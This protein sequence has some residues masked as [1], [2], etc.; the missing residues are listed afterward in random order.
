[1]EAWGPDVEVKVYGPEVSRVSESDWLT[2]TRRR[3]I[4]IE[5]GCGLGKST[6]MTQL[7]HGSARSLYVIA[8]V[9]QG[10]AWM[11]AQH[12][13]S[14]ILGTIPENVVMY[15]TD[16]W[17]GARH[18]ACTYESLWKLCQ[19]NAPFVDFSTVFLDEA[20]SIMES[21][22]S[23]TNSNHML[24]NYQALELFM[25]RASRVVVSDAHLMSSIGVAEFIRNTFDGDEVSLRVF[26]HQAITPRVTLFDHQ[27]YRDSFSYNSMKAVTGKDGAPAFVC[28]SSLGGVRQFELVSDGKQTEMFT[29]KSDSNRMREVWNDPDSQLADHQGIIATS[30][31]AIGCD[32]TI[33]VSRVWSDIT[34]NNGPDGRTMVQLCSRARNC[35]SRE[36]YALADF[37]NLDAPQHFEDVV[38]RYRARRDARSAVCKTAV[39][40]GAAAQIAADSAWLGTATDSRRSAPESELRSQ[41]E[42]GCVGERMVEIVWAPKLLVRLAARA[43]QSKTE[44]IS[45]SF[46]RHGL[47]SGWTF[48]MPTDELDDKDGAK[49]TSVEN[50]IT[51]D[52]RDDRD[53]AQ[54]KSVEAMYNDIDFEQ[55]MELLNGVRE[56]MKKRKSTEEDK[57]AMFE[58]LKA[59]VLFDRKPPFAVAMHAAT[60]RHLILNHLCFDIDENTLARKDFELMLSS[61]GDVGSRSRFDADRVSRMTKIATLAGFADAREPGQT[62]TGAKIEENRDAIMAE[63]DAILALGGARKSRAAGKR[64]VAAATAAAITRVFSA[65]NGYEVKRSKRTRLNGVRAFTYELVDVYNVNEFAKS[66]RPVWL[67]STNPATVDPATLE[68]PVTKSQADAA[69][70]VKARRDAGIMLQPDIAEMISMPPPVSREPVPHDDPTSMVT[71][72]QAAADYL[73]TDV[74]D[75]MY[76]ESSGWFADDA[77]ERRRKRRRT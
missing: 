33:P 73:G 7:M 13:A 20:C 45:I 77:A 72:A 4:G 70:R 62:T 5:A 41:W 40:S 38:D 59:M 26:K 76:S 36:I 25:S 49:R 29:G 11:D 67:A 42:V 57:Q 2:G 63:V 18:I 60:H 66:C 74:D 54:T 34:S 51:V 24:N 16:G 31:C 10:G 37:R 58:L 48:W 65:F 6:A 30:A 68:V 35:L 39:Y 22:V 21:A 71:A 53:D 61:T 28:S 9:T 43:E 47:K 15:G 3:V 75:L 55:G 52:S 19:P 14:L 1:M 32:V 12:K 17:T 46:I 23:P 27:R 8:R 56:R 69:K 44:G 50:G 64:G